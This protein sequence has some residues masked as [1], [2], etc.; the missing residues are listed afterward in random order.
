MIK[1]LLFIFL[2]VFSLNLEAQQAGQE[3]K[4]ET[5]VQRYIPGETTEIKLS[6]YPVPVNN[7]TFTI[8]TDHDISLVKVTNIIGQD[9]YKVKYNTPRQLVRITLDG[10]QR[11]MYLVTIFFNDGRRIVKKIMIEE[12]K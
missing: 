11:G 3:V 5:S 8:R 10:P 6:I 9:I 12:S 4:T 2:L 1:T 7:N